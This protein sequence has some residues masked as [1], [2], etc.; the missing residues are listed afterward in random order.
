MCSV[1]GC[2][3]ASSDK[4]SNGAANSG[5]HHSNYHSNHH[6]NHHNN[7]HDHNHE[8]S[9][10]HHHFGRNEAGLSVPGLDASELI[11]IEKDILSKNDVYAEANRKRFADLGVLALNLVSSPGAGKT[12]LLEASIAALCDVM[13]V[14]VIE[15]DQQ[16]SNDAERIRVLGVPAVQLNTGRGCHLDAHMVGHAMEDLPLRAG[17]VAFIENVGNLVC[18]A[19]FDL[20]EACK[21]VILSVTEGDDKPLKYPDMFAAADLFILNKI[22]L[23]PYVDFDADKAVERALR[24]NPALDVIKVSARQGI[25]MGGWID[26]IVLMAEQARMAESAAPIRL[27]PARGG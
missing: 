6:S 2:G 25:G 17:G 20:G 8:H 18:P 5:H 16:T 4:H 22:D 9:G 3:D 10:G 24:I 1:C 7:H 11:S 15:G 12:T 21:V 23:L 19:S 27:H 26:R 13:P 14:C